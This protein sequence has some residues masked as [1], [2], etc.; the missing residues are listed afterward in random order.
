MRQIGLICAYV[1]ISLHM[2]LH[3]IV[4]EMS[5]AIYA[6]LAT[7]PLGLSLCNHMHLAYL[8]LAFFSKDLV[9]VPC[10]KYWKVLF[11]D[12]LPKHESMH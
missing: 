5:Q 4:L 3:G 7:P 9:N 2:K 10:A 11:A 6:S 8:V 12:P 1:A